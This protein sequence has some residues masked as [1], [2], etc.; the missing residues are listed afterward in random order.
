MAFVGRW[1]TNESGRKLVHNQLIPSPI[2]YS[3]N[4]V[5][6]YSQP[7]FPKVPPNSILRNPVICSYF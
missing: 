2:Y 4:D 5:S 1:N 6:Y 3:V 7:G